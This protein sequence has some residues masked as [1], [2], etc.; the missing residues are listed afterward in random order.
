MNDGL[1]PGDEFNP[2][3]F[4]GVAEAAAAM[5]DN[6]GKR[7]HN[8]KNHAAITKLVSGHL[9]DIKSAASKAAEGS[10]ESVGHSLRFLYLSCKA[11]HKVYQTEKRLRP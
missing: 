2:Y 4:K 10:V 5:L 8:D 3:D 6:E 11:C 1:L 7:T 9:E